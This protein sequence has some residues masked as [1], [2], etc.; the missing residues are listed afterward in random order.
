MKKQHSENSQHHKEAKVAA[1]AARHPISIGIVDNDPVV[2][3]ALTA[4]FSDIPTPIHVQWSVCSA[5][6]ALT[7]CQSPDMIP[8]VLLTDISMPGIGGAE[9]AQRIHTEHPDVGIVAVTAFG[10]ENTGINPEDSG[11]LTVLHKEAT[12]QEYVRAIA[13]A[14]RRD[15]LCRWQEYS[16]SFVRM[17]LTRTEIAILQE[18]LRG[19][20]T[21]ATARLLH[22]SEGTI[23]THMNNAYK[24]M[25]VHSRAEAIRICV[26]EH[27]L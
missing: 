25:G 27:I 7:C 14:S 2:A 1:D 17:Q 3:K 9:L 20:T 10:T 15:D 16:W 8:D 12:L 21:S 23:K 5:T 18:Y 11:I 19:R 6:E 4:M 22:M 13:A 24:K 26:R